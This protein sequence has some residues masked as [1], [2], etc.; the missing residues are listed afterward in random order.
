MSVAVAMIGCGWWP[1]RVLLPALERHP[2]ARIAALVDPDPA[3]LATT[4]AAFRVPAAST[5]ATTEALFDA[6]VPAPD[7]A[8]VAVPHALH[9]PVARLVLERGVH[10]LLEK[11]M[12]IEPRHARELITLADA[13]GAHLLLDYPYNFNAQALTL[14]RE[15]AAGRIGPVEHVSCLYGSTVRALYGGDPEPY[16]EAFG[17]PVNAPAAATYS[18]PALSGGGQG[19]TQLTHAIALLLAI[20]GLRPAAVCAFT[21]GFELP[22]D[23]ADAVA[24][25]FEDGAVGTLSSA[26]SVLPGQQEV[27]RCELFGRD[28]HV[29]FD[30]NGGEATIHGADGAIEQLPSPP[31]DE[32]NPE[33]VVVGHLVDVVLGRAVNRVPGELGLAAVEVVAALYRSAAERRVVDLQELRQ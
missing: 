4:A 6:L 3:R 26:G 9:H 25:Q 22:V 27:V 15:L 11:P 12:T 24:V 8:I 21:A 5:F 32:R 16:R 18:D 20:S 7:A 31:A 30:V 19:Q 17:Y 1:T 28:G 2:E 29:L 13:R 23:L 14:Q 10:L 33:P